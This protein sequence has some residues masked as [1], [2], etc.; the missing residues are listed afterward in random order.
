MCAS[1]QDYGEASAPRAVPALRLQLESMKPCAQ[2]EGPNGLSCGGQLHERGIERM[3]AHLEEQVVGSF[4]ANAEALRDL[5]AV[6]LKRCQEVDPSISGVKYEIRRRDGWRFETEDIEEVLREPNGDQS[7]IVSATARVA[8]S[9]IT[10][11]LAVAFDKS[12]TLVIRGDDRAR[13]TLMASDIRI[14]VR[15][16]MRGPTPLPRGWSRW[17]VALVVASLALFCTVSFYAYNT[18]RFAS[19]QRSALKAYDQ[20]TMAAFEKTSEAQQEEI[21][22]VVDEL[23]V[24]LDVGSLEDKL[25]AMIR[26]DLYYEGMSLEPSP[27][28]PPPPAILQEELGLSPFLLFIVIP[29]SAFALTLVLL[30]LFLPNRPS[31]FA[32]GAALQREARIARRRQNIIWGLGASLVLGIVSS[33]LAARYF[34]A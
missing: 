14:L 6:I 30:Y 12:V 17:V 3:T 20:V 9:T 15:D 7:A 4:R 34:G 22:Q 32:F 16:R 8:A 5:D 23:S 1:G 31:I 27:T 18:E 13:V 26:R 19:E 29:A 11:D 2:A 10:F 21:R 25:D 28:Q 24:A 33:I